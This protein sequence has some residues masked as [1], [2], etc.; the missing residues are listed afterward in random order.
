MKNTG[1]VTK[2]SLKGRRLGQLHPLCR[3]EEPKKNS[4]ATDNSYFAY[5]LL[6]LRVRV[7]GTSS[8]TDL[9]LSACRGSSGHC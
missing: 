7:H 2:Y 5:G 8:T 4:A 1:Q 6:L 3:P 9:P